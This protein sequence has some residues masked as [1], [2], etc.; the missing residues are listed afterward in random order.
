MRKLLLGLLL[1]SPSLLWA[2]GSQVNTQ[3]Q[4]AVGMA[5]AG[6]ALFVDE[7]S[8][9]YSPGALAKMN[10][11]AVSANVSAIMYRSA[12][13]EA[14]ANEVYDTKFKITPPFS[15]FATFSPEGA[16]WKA[17]LG[18]YTPFGGSVNWGE[19]WPGKYELNHL[20]MRAIYI[21]PTISYKITENLGIGAGFVY[22]L[23][24]V[25]LSRSLPV[26]GPDGKSGRA[27]LSGTGTGTGFNVGAHYHVEDVFALSVS[28]RSKVN[29]KL[30]NGD[31]EFTVPDALASSFPN[32][33]FNAELPLPAS[34]NIG[35]SFPVSS[36]VDIAAD[37]T[38]L[39]YSVY[40]KLV[41]D[42]KDNTPVLTDT[43]QEKNYKNGFSGKIGVNYQTTPKL[44]LRAGM[45]YVASPVRAEYV[46]P[47]TPDNDRIMGSIGFTYGISDKWE[48]SGAYVLQ[49]LKSRHVTSVATGLSGI[50]ETNIHAPGIS[51]TYKW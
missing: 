15:V 47:E 28:Y 31:A 20:Q 40:K 33:T 44:A 48:L 14:G 22:N 41:F 38:F 37:A 10:G 7:S 32:T 12:F 23:G 24:L 26:S 34:L 39:N 29:T 2:Q 27:E 11:N 45:G 4:K 3:S 35:L 51:L 17:G 46:S 25:D 16:R 49:H 21:Q 5:G 13:Q 9:F 6:S 1:A 30:K 8:I 43:E 50:Y 36:K 42:Y 18:I 19:E